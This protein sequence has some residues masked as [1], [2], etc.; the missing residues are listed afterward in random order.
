MRLR[1]GGDRRFADIAI[2]LLSVFHLIGDPTLG[3]YIHFVYNKDGDAVPVI[4]APN[5]DAG[6]SL[7]ARRSKFQETRC[8]IMSI[9]HQAHQR[10]AK[11][12]LAPRRA[13][14]PRSVKRRKNE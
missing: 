2:V 1:A 5:V 11:S 13:S 10:A 7:K 3:T 6:F 4:L 12:C 14:G 8:S 9:Q